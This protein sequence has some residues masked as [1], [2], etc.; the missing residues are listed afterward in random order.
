[1][2]QRHITTIVCQIKSLSF[3]AV[4]NDIKRMINGKTSDSVSKLRIEAEQMLYVSENR[5]LINTSRTFMWGK[6]YKKKLSPLFYR[7][8]LFHKPSVPSSR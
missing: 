8:P 7:F 1:M 4:F 5:E 2:Y 3:I 6:I